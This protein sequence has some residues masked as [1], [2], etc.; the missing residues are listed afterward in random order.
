MAQLVL[1]AFAGFLGWA[2]YREA[3]NF[4]KVHRRG[5]GGMSARL[6]CLTGILAGVVAACFAAPFLVAAFAGYSGYLGAATFERLNRDRLF[7][8]AAMLYG[9]AGFFIG[10]FGALFLGAPDWAVICALVVLMGALLLMRDENNALREENERLSASPQPG[11]PPG[12]P[13]AQ[14]DPPQTQ[15]PGDPAP[16]R[17]TYL[18]GPPEASR[19]RAAASRW[20]QPTAG[21]ARTDHLLPNRTEAR[22]RPA[23]G[24]D[25]LPD[26]R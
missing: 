15:P 2:A 12:P 17:K 6:C 22:P 7:G 11:P 14:P 23:D 26:R 4:E 3:E 13:P 8:L 5:P 19:P 24:N 20:S 25:L 16:A 9:V 21:P 18:F 1:V 10:L